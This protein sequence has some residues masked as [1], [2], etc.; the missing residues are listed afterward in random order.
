M[1]CKHK[2]LEILKKVRKLFPVF[3][4]E[5]VVGGRRVWSEQSHCFR[6]HENNL[7]SF[8]LIPSFL[9]STFPPFLLFILLPSSFF[10]LSPSLFLLSFASFS[11]LLS[12]VFLY[13]NA[14]PAAAE[15][16]CSLS[17]C[18]SSVMMVAELIIQWHVMVLAGGVV[19]THRS[20][21]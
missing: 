4:R 16:I 15:G 2:T 9:S 11:F 13:S 12:L 20:F 14:F 10:T 6:R 5:L 18:H 21:I 1:K 17:P 3:R 7:L 8:L 19:K